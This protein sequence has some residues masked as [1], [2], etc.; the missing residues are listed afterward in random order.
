MN[1]NEGD[2]KQRILLLKDKI[3]CKTDKEFTN[4]IKIRQQSYSSI[5]KGTRPMGVDIFYKILVNIPNVNPQWLEYGEG[6]MFLDRSKS[7]PKPLDPMDVIEDLRYTVDLQ[8]DYINNL[9]NQIK[10]GCVPQAGN[11]SCADAV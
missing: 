5:M 3:G 9:K 10:R 2:K 7:T 6:N 4:L 8:K 1:N 11:V